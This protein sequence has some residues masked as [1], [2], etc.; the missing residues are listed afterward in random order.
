MVRVWTRVTCVKRLLISLCWLLRDALN[1]GR[2][3]GQQAGKTRLEWVK[4]ARDGER[5]RERWRERKREV[6]REVER[7]EEREGGMERDRVRWRN[8]WRE[9]SVGL[10]IHS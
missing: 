3:V 1:T 10:H 4:L 2:R 5:E 7:E 6:E 9:R 8:R